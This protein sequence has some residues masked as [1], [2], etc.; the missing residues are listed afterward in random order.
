[1]TYINPISGTAMAGAA[2]QEQ[3]SADKTRQL[4]RQQQVKRNV[5]AAS[6]HFEHSVENAEEVS[7][8]QEDKRRQQQGGTGSRKKQRKPDEGDLPHIDTTA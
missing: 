6:D 2:Q 3:L 4:R 8:V 5:A 7:P 1:M